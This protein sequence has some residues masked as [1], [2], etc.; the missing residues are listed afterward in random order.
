MKDLIFILGM[1]LFAKQICIAVLILIVALVIFIATRPASFRIERSA[2]IGAPADVV[3][4]MINDHRQFVRW[5]PW[6]KL[7]PNMKR[8]FEGSQSG[9][10]A[11]YAWSGNAKVG[12]GR[13][14][15]IDSKAGQSVSIKL[16]MFKPFNCT[17]QV[18]FKLAPSGAGTRVSWI[19]E[20]KNGFMSKAFSLVMNMDKMCG[21]IFE[22]GLVNLNTLAQSE[23][24]KAQTH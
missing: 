8:T 6:E 3:F 12:A 5:S 24:P 11:I 17:N 23:T 19:M 21:T 18:T 1:S 15:I 16:E 20:G 10:G 2:Q 14:T 7:D 9:P 13:S 22:K 4:P